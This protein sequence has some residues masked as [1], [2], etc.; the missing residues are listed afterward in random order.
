MSCCSA[1]GLVCL[2]VPCLSQVAGSIPVL[3]RSRSQRWRDH[4][5]GRGSVSAA[6]HPPWG[7]PAPRQ[8]S[9]QESAFSRARIEECLGRRLGPTSPGFLRSLTQPTWFSP[10][11][12]LPIED[13]TALV[14]GVLDQNGLLWIHGP[15][16]LQLRNQ[17]SILQKGWNTDL[18]SVRAPGLQRPV[19][20]LGTEHLSSGGCLWDPAD[21]VRD[22]SSSGAGAKNNSSHSQ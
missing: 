11:A 5:V 16:W 4:D 8:A 1:S 14:S 2:S 20:A 15:V 7:F 6:A 19:V 9:A 3:K 12:A 21:P 18:G 13:A 22:G 17:A 10:P